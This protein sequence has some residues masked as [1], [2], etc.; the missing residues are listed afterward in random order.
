MLNTSEP[1]TKVKSSINL[2]TLTWNFVTLIVLWVVT[3]NK[4]YAPDRQTSISIKQCLFRWQKSIAKHFHAPLI[5]VWIICVVFDN[6][7]EEN[8]DLKTSW[9]IGHWMEW[10]E[11]KWIDFV[12]VRNWGN[13]D[14]AIYRVLYT[15]SNRKQTFLFWW[16]C[17]FK[18]VND[19]ILPF[20]LA[21]HIKIVNYKNNCLCARE[22]FIK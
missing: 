22:F 20:C 19:K 6:W 4:I 7:S 1:P 14:R 16:F 21:K 17:I 11:N 18:Q 13:E 8:L 3:E 15:W 10:N 5:V 9:Q 2:S 12:Y